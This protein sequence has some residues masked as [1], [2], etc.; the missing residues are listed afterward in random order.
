MDV[1]KI[2][3]EPPKDERGIRFEVLPPV[4]TEL[5]FHRSRVVKSFHVQFIEMSKTSIANVFY[6][7]VKMLIVDFPKLP[8]FISAK[9]YI[10]R[11]E[12][13]KEK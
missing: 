12:L 3:P 5:S 11:E 7:E 8:H 6:V 10:T 4:E 13:H 9:G 2:Q 1:K